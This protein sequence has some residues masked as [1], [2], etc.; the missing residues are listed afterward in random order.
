MNNLNWSYEKDE[1]KNALWVTVLDLCTCQSHL[2][3][4]K[5]LRH[6]TLF[7]TVFSVGTGKINSML[8]FCSVSNQW[9]CF[10]LHLRQYGRKVTLNKWISHILKWPACLYTVCLHKV[11]TMAPSS[12]SIKKDMEDKWKYTIHLCCNNS[13]VQNNLKMKSCFP[14][15]IFYLDL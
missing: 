13:S 4:T 10:G 12:G 2:V 8:Y 3:D 15:I 11:Y 1:D 7:C 5:H 9:F 6:T 14:K